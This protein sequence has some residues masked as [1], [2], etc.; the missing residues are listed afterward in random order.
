MLYNVGQ[1]DYNKIT[2]TRC[3]FSVQHFTHIRLVK[4]IFQI[5][6]LKTISTKL[7]QINL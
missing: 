6:W 7:I 3:L 4:N 2:N 5:I 1:Q